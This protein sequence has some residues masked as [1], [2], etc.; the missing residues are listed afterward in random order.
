[1]TTS[2]VAKIK[3]IVFQVKT[4]QLLLKQFLENMG[5][6]YSNIWSH[7]LWT[8][9]A[10]IIFSR[11]LQSIKLKQSLGSLLCGTMYPLEDIL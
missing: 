7:C 5:T 9:V 1:M 3:N 10:K 2:R 8:K 4:N 11:N 6:F